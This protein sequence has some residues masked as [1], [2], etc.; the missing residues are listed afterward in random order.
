MDNQFLIPA[1][2]KRSMLIFNMFN[3]FDIVLFGC[4][5]GLTLIL[6]VIL[7]ISGL[8]VALIALAPAL[9]TGF[10]VVPVPNY[11]NILT[12]IKS[13]INFYLGRRDFIWKGWCLPHG[14]DDK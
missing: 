3:K 12:I 9:I 8:L 5:I 6:L 11:H 10:L 2:S 13:V 1:N 14:E 7:D 4:G